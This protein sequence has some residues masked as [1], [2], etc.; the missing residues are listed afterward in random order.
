MEWGIFAAANSDLIAEA[1]RND[2]AERNQ[3]LQDV[4][5][6]QELPKNIHINNSPSIS[7]PQTEVKIEEN[8]FPS[9][10]KQIILT[11]R[12][13]VIKRNREILRRVN[14][15]LGLSN[16]GRIVPG[17]SSALRVP[18]ARY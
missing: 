7:I 12:N 6:S 11:N 17:S 9:D 3:N 2:S 5:A 4:G 14:E 16:R 8:E 1:W 18:L 13:R 10:R 15:E